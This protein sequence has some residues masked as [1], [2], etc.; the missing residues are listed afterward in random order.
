MRK[1]AKGIIDI[2]VRYGMLVVAGFLSTQIFYVLFSKLTVY[3]VSFLLGLFFSVLPLGNTLIING[4]AIEIIGPCV[5]ASAYYL[6]LILNLSIP[7]LTV[8]KR[9]AVFLF[10]SF[11]FLLINVL[12][13]FFLSLMFI[14]GFPLFDITHKL[15]WYAGSTVFVVAIWFLAVKL[16][17]V[18]DIP[19]YSDLKS[20]MLKRKKKRK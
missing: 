17:K 15:F 7:N 2:A 13:I 16:F 8:K 18:K 4:A 10:T 14:N 19:F 5:A 6:L 20:L 3:P 12:R 11:S 1:E 9:L